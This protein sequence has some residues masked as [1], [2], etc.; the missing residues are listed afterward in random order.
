MKSDT[1]RVCGCARAGDQNNNNNAF[2]CNLHN[3]SDVHGNL[4]TFGAV[5]ASTFIYFSS[6]YCNNES[7]YASYMFR[8][9][10][11]TMHTCTFRHDSYLKKRNRANTSKKMT[12]SHASPLG[13]SSVVRSMCCFYT[14]MAFMFKVSSRL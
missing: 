12:V 10:L 3:T 1:P 9:T 5:L 6:F 14:K 2:Y 4:V 11:M 8:Q 7:N 13:R